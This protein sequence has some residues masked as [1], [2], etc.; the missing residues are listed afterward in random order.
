MFHFCL[1]PYSRHEEIESI[2]LRYFVIHKHKPAYISFTFFVIQ[3]N[4]RLSSPY[5]KASINLLDTCALPE[6]S[7]E[8]IF[9][10]LFG[11]GRLNK[12]KA[13]TI[14]RKEN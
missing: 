8:K 3:R 1:L 10:G 7:I 9:T 6:K 2:V 4:E 14:K 5:V 11:K 12:I 13:E